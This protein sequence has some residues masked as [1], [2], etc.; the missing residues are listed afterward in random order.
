MLEVLSIGWKIVAKR[1]H[2]VI[3]CVSPGKIRFAWNSIPSGI[4]HDFSID[5]PFVCFCKAK[6]EHVCRS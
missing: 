6:A 1:K 2:G 5:F 3:D 4:F